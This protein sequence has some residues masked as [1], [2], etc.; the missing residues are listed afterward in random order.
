LLVLLAS[1]A[2]D[3]RALG[4]LGKLKGGERQEDVGFLKVRRG[5]AEERR[6]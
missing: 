4:L 1:S 2:E 6:G 5:R 3:I